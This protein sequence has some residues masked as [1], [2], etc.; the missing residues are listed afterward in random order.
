[1]KE[2]G[3]KKI[4]DGQG[5]KKEAVDKTNEEETEKK[6]LRGKKNE[7]KER[8]PSRRRSARLEIKKVNL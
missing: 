8:L 1:M 7:M 3:K 2:K 6:M 5:R 4:Q